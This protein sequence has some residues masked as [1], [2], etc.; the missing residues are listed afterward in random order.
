MINGQPPEWGSNRPPGA[1]ELR[2]HGPAMAPPAPRIMQ[3]GWDRCRYEGRAPGRSRTDTGDPFRGPASSLGLRGLGHDTPAGPRPFL[4]RRMG[5]EKLAPV[6]IFNSCAAIGECE[7][8]P[9]RLALDELRTQRSRT[10]ALL[11]RRTCA[12]Y[13]P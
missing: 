12:R 7:A 13:R 9:I 6:H 3:R 10:V 2:R 8:L 5:R 11:G 4:L 1:A